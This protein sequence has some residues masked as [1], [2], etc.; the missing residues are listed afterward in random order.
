MINHRR[1]VQPAA[2]QKGISLANRARSPSFFH[3]RRGLR[4]KR[5]DQYAGRSAIESMRGIDAAAEKITR[6]LQRKP[7]FPRRYFAAV[8]QKTRTFHHD[9]DRL[10][11]IK[12]RNRRHRLR[13][14]HS[15]LPT[16]IQRS[17]VMRSV[18]RFMCGDRALSTAFCVATDTKPVR[19]RTDAGKTPLDLRKNLSPLI[20]HFCGH[21]T[22][23]DK[24]RRGFNWLRSCLFFKHNRFPYQA[25]LFSLNQYLP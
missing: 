19:V 14:L 16:K 11:F 5:K 18:R 13:F 20:H 25:L 10:I 22:F 2:H 9:A 4:V 6:K 15:K 12:R 17:I 24:N 21:S 23:T 1:P 8:H 3:R 7:F